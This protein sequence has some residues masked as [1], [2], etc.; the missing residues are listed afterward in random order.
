MLIFVFNFF[1]FCFF[2]NVWQ[3]FIELEFNKKKWNSIQRN[4]DYFMLIKFNSIHLKYVA[5]L[6]LI[7][8]SCLSPISL[9]I[10]IMFK[11][12]L[13]FQFLLLLFYFKI[14]FM[15]NFL[16][17]QNFFSNLRSISIIFR[18]N[19][20][21]FSDSSQLKDLKNQRWSFFFNYY[22]RRN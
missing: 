12:L 21:C 13:F 22:K 4:R 14:H 6:K 10:H 5:F 8:N 2:N 1:P 16:K 15:S 19:K 9:L 18:N 20:I 3:V 17:L 11:Y 7:R